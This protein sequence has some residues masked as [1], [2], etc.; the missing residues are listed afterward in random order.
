M[1]KSLPLNSRAKTTAL[2]QPRELFTYS[3]DIEGN[4]HYEN[5]E[6]EA[7]SYYYLPDSYIDYG[8]DLQSGYSKF[9]QIPEEA[10][11]KSFKYLLKAIQNYE[12]KQNKKSQVI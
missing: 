4:Y 12:I 9:K 1:S 5:A 6:R 10:N 3:R 11:T 7:M 8:I 2:K